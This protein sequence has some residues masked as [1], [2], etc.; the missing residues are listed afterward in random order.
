MENV[1]KLLR[2][3]FY[4]LVFTLG[5]TMLCVMSEQLKGASERSADVI[6]E[7]NVLYEAPL[8]EH[9]E[10]ATRAELIALLLEDILY[11]IN[12]ADPTAFYRL[13]AGSYHPEDLAE[14]TLTGRRYD[15]SYVYNERGDIIT[16]SYQYISD[17]A[18]EG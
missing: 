12:I 8:T 13:I 1:I 10:I 5:I 18:L 15:K 9:K 17:D 3:S 4:V 2:I 11:N 16:I 14:I 6:A 7:D